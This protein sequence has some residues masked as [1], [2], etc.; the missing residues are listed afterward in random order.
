MRVF[1]STLL[2]IFCIL[3]SVHADEESAFTHD[4]LQKFYVQGSEVEVANNGIFV[5]FQG[6][7]FVCHRCICG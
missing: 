4:G 6:D 2:F 7:I 1:I 3:N 5:N